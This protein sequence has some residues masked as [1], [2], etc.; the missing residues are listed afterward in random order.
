M[1]DSKVVLV[2]NGPNLGILGRREK[3]IYGEKT[4]SDIVADLQNRARA[5]GLEVKPFQSNSEGEII[6]FI[7]QNA[8]NCCGIIINPGALTHYGYALY[9]C[10]RAVSVPIVEVHLSNI[11]ER[12]EF[13]HTSVTAPA[14]GGVICGFGSYSYVLALE[15]IASRNDLK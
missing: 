2:V 14:A 4:L 9:D 7:E 15:Y 3:H 5:Y 6:D 13:R 8:D 12:E 1:T 11:F 10:L